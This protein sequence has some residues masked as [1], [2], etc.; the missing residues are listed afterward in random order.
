MIHFLHSD[1]LAGAL[2][3]PNVLLMGFLT[4]GLSFLFVTGP[5]LPLQRL[6]LH[7]LPLSSS[8]SMLVLHIA[9]SN[10]YLKILFSI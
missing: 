8:L 3:N 6:N 9:Y 1:V 5:D 4:S 7:L 2:Q 10:L